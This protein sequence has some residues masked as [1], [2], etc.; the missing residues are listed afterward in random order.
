MA[1]KV[2]IY[3]FEIFSMTELKYYCCSLLGL[4]VE[5]V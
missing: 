3:V 2:D 1:N 5:N 4:L